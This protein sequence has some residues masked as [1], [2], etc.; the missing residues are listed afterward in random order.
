MSNRSD[1]NTK[2]RVHEALWQRFKAVT[3][4]PLDPKGYLQ[5]ENIEANLI[6]GVD[7]SL[8]REDYEKGAGN[9]LTQKFRAVHSSA[10]LVANTF[11]RWKNEPEKPSLFGLSS[12]ASLKL[13]WR[14]NNWFTNRPPNLDV[15]MESP[16]CR[17]AVESKLTEIF[18]NKQPQFSSRYTRDRFPNCED[19]WWHLLEEA[20]QW[21]RS[22]FDAAQIIKH[23]LGLS[24][25]WEAGRE[26]H[27]VYLYWEPINASSF[28]EYDQHTQD[29]KKF[30]KKVKNSK[31]KFQSMT[32]SRLCQEWLKI[33]ALKAHA[34]RIVERYEVKI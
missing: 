34:E 10:A 31:I 13:E 29:L 20:C 19:V 14:P 5:K 3:G 16:G 27:L 11:G 8:F 33:S 12:F 2:H 23:Y 24:N 25:V 7:L 6:A 32:Y 21:P 26:T 15:L 18:V 17:V 22:R 9:E 28:R 4:N 30:G 1:L